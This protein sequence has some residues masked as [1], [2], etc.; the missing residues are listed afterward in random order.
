MKMKIEDIIIP[1]SFTEKA[2]SINKMIAYKNYYKEH[3][4]FK[5]TIVVNGRELINGYTT[6]L[7]CK[8]FGI[9]EVEVTTL[10]YRTS[11]T[12]YV[13]GKHPED[14]SNTEYVWRL[15]KDNQ[16]GLNFD[17]EIEAGDIV[18]VRTKK[19]DTEVVV[20]KVELLNSPPRAGTIKVCLLP[21]GFKRK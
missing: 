9:N 16:T 17:C 20:T 6:Y 13:Y 3:G 11:P 19:G 2:P 14:E 21:N 8:E 12:V 1:R 5:A 7:L 10:S 18:P 15:R 4:K